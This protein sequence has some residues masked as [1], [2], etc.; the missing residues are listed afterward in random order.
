MTK[1]RIEL[2][3]VTL[4]NRYEFGSYFNHVYVTR[5]LYKFVD[6]SGK[7]YVWKTTTYAGFDTKITVAGVERYAFDGIHNGDILDIK[8]TIKGESVYNGEPQTELE[9]VKILG[10]S[11]KAET[12]EEKKARIEAEK[13]AKEEK[14]RASLK[15]GDKIMRMTYKNYKEHYADCETVE[16]SFE[17]HNGRPSTIEV[18]VR[19]GRLV[20]SGVRGEHYAGYRFVNE[21][22]EKITYRAV[23]AENAEKRVNKENPN[24]KWELDEIFYYDNYHR[25][26]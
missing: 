5:Y 22:G 17:E 11:F 14:Q 13:K 26:W 25:I 15:D 2:K 8:G 20:P 23:S 24:N 3:N 9:R 10:R 1:E 16:N 21:K 7:V 19:S 4:A 18:I 6:E 12:P